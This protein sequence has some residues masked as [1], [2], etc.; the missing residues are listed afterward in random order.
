MRK[1]VSLLALALFTQDRGLIRASA[2]KRA[3]STRTR[4][5]PPIMRLQTP[6]HTTPR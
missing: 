5:E 2:R 4:A 1:V 6:F 3:K